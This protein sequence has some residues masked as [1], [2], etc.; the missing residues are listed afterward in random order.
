MEAGV[1]PVL[2]DPSERDRGADGE[3][4]FRRSRSG[5]AAGEPHALSTVFPGETRVLSAGHNDLQL[6]RAGLQPAAVL[7]AAHRDRQWRAEGYS[8]W[9]ESHRSG[10]EREL[11]VARCADVR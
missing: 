2:Q 7:L 5:R 6:W 10:T 3:H 1:R 9:A 11:R 8:R 4:R